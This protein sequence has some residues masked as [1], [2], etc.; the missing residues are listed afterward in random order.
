[1]TI[2]GDRNIF[3]GKARAV[4]LV[5]SRTKI[6]ASMGTGRVRVVSRTTVAEGVVNMPAADLTIQTGGIFT[7]G[8]SVKSGEC[9]SLTIRKT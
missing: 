6:E 3:R 8:T 2:E 1:M 5:K 9:L 7:G 4:D